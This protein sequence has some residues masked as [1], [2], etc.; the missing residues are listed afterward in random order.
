MQ[1]SVPFHTPRPSPAWHQ[2]CEKLI[3]F[4]NTILRLVF[5]PSRF[6]LSVQIQSSILDILAM[7]TK[8]EV[9]APEAGEEKTVTVGENWF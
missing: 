9:P 8:P 7:F 1:S 4:Y 6:D 5:G 2:R 3:N